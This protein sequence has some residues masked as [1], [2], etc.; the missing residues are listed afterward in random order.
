MIGMNDSNIDTADNALREDPHRK[1][2][3]SAWSGWAM[4]DFPWPSNMPRLASRHRHRLSAPARPT[5]STPAIPTSAMSLGGRARSRSSQA[6]KLRATTDF[7]VIRDL[8]TVNICVPTPLRK[9]KD[10]DMSYIV[11]ACEEIAKYFHPGHARDSGIR[12]PI[13]ARPT[14]WCCRCWRSPD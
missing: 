11:A 4:S 5:A 13:R 9:T 14:N 12:P 3:G 8:D 10:P 2:P 7:S 1:P 6:G